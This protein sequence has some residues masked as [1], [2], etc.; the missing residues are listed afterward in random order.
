M[1]EKTYRFFSILQNILKEL[2]QRLDG[3]RVEILHD[4][5]AGHPLAVQMWDASEF[6]QECHWFDHLSHFLR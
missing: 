6:D 4:A 1:K 5:D 3:F 2:N